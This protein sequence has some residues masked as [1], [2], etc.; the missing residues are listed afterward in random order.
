MTRAK[1]G[2][3]LGSWGF[4]PMGRVGDLDRYPGFPSTSLLAYLQARV[5]YRAPLFPAALF[6]MFVKAPAGGSQIT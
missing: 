6:G 4:A 1:S 3:D 5:L 2:E